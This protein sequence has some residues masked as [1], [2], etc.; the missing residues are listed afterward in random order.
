MEG[1]EKKEVLPHEKKNNKNGEENKNSI[2]AL[3][4][5]NCFQHNSPLLPS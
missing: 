3:I 1:S 2:I 5:R 4:V